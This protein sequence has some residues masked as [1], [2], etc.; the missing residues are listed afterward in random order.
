MV[1]IVFFT[2]VSHTK[3][4]KNLNSFQRVH[5][6]RQWVN[7]AIVAG[8][9]ASFQESAGGK[10][11]VY[12][13]PL[14]GKIGLLIYGI[15]WLVRYHRDPP[16][17][18]ITEPSIVGIL[19]FFGKIVYSIKWVVD[20]WDIP[21]RCHSQ[22]ITTHLR[23]IITRRIFRM[24]YKYADLFI[25]SI[26]P[27]FE[28]KYFQIP[29][30]KMLL[31]DNAIVLNNSASKPWEKKSPNSFNIFC[32]RSLYTKDM[33]LDVLSDA[34]IQLKNKISNISLT[35][36]GEIPKEVEPQVKI[37]RNYQNVEFIGFVEFEKLNDLI[38]DADVCVVPFKNVPDLA[39]TYPTKILQYLSLGKPIVAARIA[40]IRT[41]ITD[42][43]NG[44]LFN[45]GDIGDLANKIE[46]LYRDGNVRKEISKNA[47]DLGQKYD[48]RVKNKI[49]FNRIQQLIGKNERNENLVNTGDHSTLPN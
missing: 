42:G 29:K 19:G 13:A 30:T 49:I 39:Q 26:L 6:L 18:V 45:P 48:G 16:D 2:S 31:L 46:L 12:E 22:Y 36:V 28:L 7:L 3:N 25:T 44:L 24:L 43:Y 41:M 37:L 38:K 17:A 20:V 33:G 23:I 1:N 11:R 21:F 27:D 47:K 9:G 15:Y 4:D 14:P 40:G 32:M 35:I 10:C 34:F 5:F 8:R